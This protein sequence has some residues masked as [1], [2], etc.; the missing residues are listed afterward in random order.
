LIIDNRDVAYNIFYIANAQ[1]KACMVLK[2][3]ENVRYD[4]ECP[5]KNN[6]PSRR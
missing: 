1:K 2:K 5:G 4:D 3:N 6:G